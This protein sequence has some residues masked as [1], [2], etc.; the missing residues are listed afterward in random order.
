MSLPGGEP[1]QLTT[2]PGDDFH[3][4]FSPDGSELTFYS[5]RHGTRDVFLISADG[6][7]EI[8]LTDSPNQEYHPAFSPDGLSIA[9]QENAAGRGY[10]MVMTRDAIGGEWSA[11][12]QLADVGDGFSEGF[13]WSPGGRRIV[14]PRRRHSIVVTTLD[15]QERV[16]MDSSAV[17]FTGVGWPEWSSDGHDVYF[18]GA[19][20]EGTAGLWALAVTGGSPRLMVRFD[21][22]ARVGSRG[23]SVTPDKLYLSLLELESDI[24]VMD[25][26]Y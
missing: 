18:L 23:I 13:R 1:R 17:G 11:P 26:V 5:I 25:L 20:R 19:D 4:D 2:D 3:P 16:V 14:Y 24:W 10:I 12:R 22:P 9:Y 6:G 21:D 7:N 15:G 8:R